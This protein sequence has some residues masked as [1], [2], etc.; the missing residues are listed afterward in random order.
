MRV[1][2][3]TSCTFSA[4]RLLFAHGHTNE[5]EIRETTWRWIG[6]VRHSER[7]VL[8]TLARLNGRLVGINIDCEDEPCCPFRSYNTLF[9]IWIILHVVH[10]SSPFS[11][12][13]QRSDQHEGTWLSIQRKCRSENKQAPAMV[14][15]RSTLKHQTPRFLHWKHFLELHVS[16]GTSPRRGTV[17]TR[18]G[19]WD[20][21][22]AFP[23][24][25]SRRPIPLNTRFHKTYGH[26]GHT[27]SWFFMYV[28]DM[29]HFAFHLSG[30]LCEEVPRG[31]F[32]QH[33]LAGWEL[34]RKFFL[35]I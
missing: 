9:H 31:G 4:S 23:I 16:A 27:S 7:V 11:N 5:P 25:S 8:Q 17:P 20:V 19:L 24:H 35:C 21:G 28:P 30:G 2:M 33:Q 3:T 34:W 1:V 10:D 29:S 32:L 6:R 14:L 22:C 15:S 12:V 26:I 13:S 18:A